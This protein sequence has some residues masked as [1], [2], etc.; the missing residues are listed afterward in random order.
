VSGE[1]GDERFE[2]VRTGGAGGGELLFQM[3]H[4]S[5]QLLYLHHDPLL[6]G[7]GRQ[8]NPCGSQEFEMPTVAPAF[9]RQ[10]TKRQKVK[11]WVDANGLKQLH[12]VSTD[13]KIKVD[14][15]RFSSVIAK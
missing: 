15:F 3:V 13:N 6:L 2:E 11:P 5:H 7:E 1:F 8:G 10:P 4:Q 12:S 9:K 14:E